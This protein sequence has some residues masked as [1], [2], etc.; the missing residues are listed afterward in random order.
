MPGLRVVEAHA[1]E[2]HQRLAEARAADGE[3]ALHAV[4]RAF[5]EVERRVQLEQIRQRVEHQRLAARRK[6]ADGAVDLFERHGFEGPGDDHGVALPRQLLGEGEDRGKR[7]E[8]EKSAVQTVLYIL[9]EGPPGYDG[10]NYELERCSGRSTQSGARA[11]PV[12]RSEEHTS[13][14][15]SLRHLVCRLLL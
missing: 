5:F 11:D 7:E 9:Y 15:Q 2:Q 4:G 1:V 6:H 3:I 14:L 10:C 12:S 13:E 8:Q